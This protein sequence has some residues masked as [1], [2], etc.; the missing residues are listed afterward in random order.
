[1]SAAL[2]VMSM[3]VRPAATAPKKPDMIE[4]AQAGFGCPM[5][6]TKLRTRAKRKAQTVQMG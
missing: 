2:R 5:Y 6:F 3:A 1:M 4:M